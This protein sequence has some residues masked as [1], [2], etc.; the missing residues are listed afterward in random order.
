MAAKVELAVISLGYK[1]PSATFRPPPPNFS[2]YN[3]TRKT[4]LKEDALVDL[5]SIAFFVIGEAILEAIGISCNKEH[6]LWL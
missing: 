5:I 6:I 3:G 1:E 4:M 2:I